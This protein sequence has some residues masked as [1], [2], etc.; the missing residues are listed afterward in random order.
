[1]ITEILTGLNI[2]EKLGKFWNWLRGRRNPPSESIA[3]R[4]VRLFDTHGW[5]QP[6]HCLRCDESG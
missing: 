4:F 5:K 6:V 3:A 1:M 2:L